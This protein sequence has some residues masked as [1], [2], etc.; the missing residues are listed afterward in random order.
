[1]LTRRLSHASRQASAAALS[2]VAAN[3]TRNC[4]AAAAANQFCFRRLST[5]AVHSHAAASTG[6][7]QPTLAAAAPPQPRRAAPASSAPTRH[8]LDVRPKIEGFREGMLTRD[9]ISASLYAQHTGYFNNTARVFG[10]AEPQSI[11]FRLLKDKDEYQRRLAGLYSSTDSCWVTPVELF[12]PFYAQS[13]ARWILDTRIRELGPLSVPKKIRTE[14]DGQVAATKEEQEKQAAREEAQAAAAAANTVASS[15]ASASASASQ[16]PPLRIIEM[17]GGNGT[18]CLGVM[19]YLSKHYPSLYERTEYTIVELSHVCHRKQK[20][21]LK[22][23][24]QPAAAISAPSKSARGAAVASS[25]PAP[26]GVRLLHMSM[27]EW[28]ELCA[29]SAGSVFVLGL[30]V[31]DN[32]PH[33]RVRR[34]EATGEL[35]AMSVRSNAP[36]HIPATAH[37]DFASEKFHEVAVPLESDRWIAEYA[38]YAPSIP[39]GRTFGSALLTP[40]LFATHGDAFTVGW[41]HLTADLFAW[42]LRHGQPPSQWYP[43][44][45]LQLLHIL[46]HYIPRHHLLLADFD[47][48]PSTVE[49]MCAP[50][51]A[52]KDAS[53]RGKTVDHRSHLIQ[54]GTADIFFP[55][56]FAALHTVYQRV[57]RDREQREVRKEGNGIDPAAKK[58]EQMQQ[59]V[60]SLDATATPATVPEARVLTTYQFMQEYARGYEVPTSVSNGWSPLHR[61]YVNMSFFLA[62]ANEP[63][64]S[65]DSTTASVTASAATDA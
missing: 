26:R 55:T 24:I 47:S 15:S 33:D 40:G 17:G 8:P 46:R 22:R 63:A 19:D 56:D 37:R 32:M 65:D 21:T 53:T 38:S 13:I 5:A 7:V 50:V 25:S 11:P 6:V 12:K 20:E 43:T 27:I 1:M 58:E 16:L 23:H 62:S 61:D 59:G 4:I 10:S 14:E 18:C 39:R 57:C 54:L 30:E 35:E 45:Q 2:F 9:F 41:S 44:T 48:L 31:L 36:G 28:R 49:G 51:V 34:N 52:S 42:S 29:P 64:T 60:A 3:S